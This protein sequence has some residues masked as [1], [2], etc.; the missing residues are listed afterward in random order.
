MF[1]KYAIDYARIQNGLCIRARQIGDT[2]HPSGRHIGKTIK[3][4][5][6]EWRIPVNCR[7]TWPLL[8]DEA[9]VLLVPGYACDQRVC[10]DEKTKHFLVWES[11]SV[12]G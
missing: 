10:P 11:L 2:M 1:L 5:M 3:K 7:D 12:T 9:G 4:L 6:N 8:C